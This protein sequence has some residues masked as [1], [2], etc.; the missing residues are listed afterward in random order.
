MIEAHEL[1]AAI[2]S[3]G[4]NLTPQAL[5]V[6]VTR[7]S[8]TGRIKFDDFVACAVRLRMLTDS[9]RRNDATQTG[10]ANF[11]YDL[12]IQTTMFS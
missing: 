8:D 9:F 7:Y 10:H 2:V 12:F 6:I 3:W 11:A 4:Y 5:R 1:H